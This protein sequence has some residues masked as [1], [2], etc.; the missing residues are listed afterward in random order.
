MSERKPYISTSQQVVITDEPP[1]TQVSTANGMVFGWLKWSTEKADQSLCLSG[2]PDDMHLLVV[3]LHRLA[4]LIELES[5]RV[6]GMERDEMDRE[7]RQAGEDERDQ[8]RI[9]NQTL[10]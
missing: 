4:D 1:N 5:E 6:V 2:R 10:R 7:M 3:E 8:H 9:A